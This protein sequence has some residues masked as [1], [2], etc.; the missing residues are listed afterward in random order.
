M[1][2]KAALPLAV[3]LAV[4]ALLCTL[5][6]AFAED[7]LSFLVINNTISSY[8]QSVNTSSSYG[9]S[10]NPD[11]PY[12]SNDKMMVPLHKLVGLTNGLNLRSQWSDDNKRLTVYDGNGTQLTF[13]NGYGTAFSGG[14]QYTAPLHR[15]KIGSVFYV[16]VPAELICNVFGL[17]YNRVNEVEFTLENGAVVKATMVRIC[18]VPY[19]LTDERFISVFNKDI[20]NAH[21]TYIKDNAPASPLPGAPSDMPPTPVSPPSPSP[22][23]VLNAVSLYLT[24]DGAPNGETAPLLDFLEANNLNALFFLPPESLAEN[25]AITRRI[26][27]RHQV[28]L[29]LDIPEGEEA[30]GRIRE[31]NALLRETALIKT[32]FIRAQNAPADSS[33]YLF[34]E[35]TETFGESDTA[36]DIAGSV[37]P[38]LTKKPEPSTVI[39]SLPHTAAA[40]DALRTLREVFLTNETTPNRIS[41]GEFPAA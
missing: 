25:P 29:L 1:K 18:T 38:L 32:W 19:L 5:P 30:L 23:P 21:E 35:A 24:F 9:P 33:E 6:P 8:G 2:R 20:I 28:G 17:Y 13:E 22:E 15:L 40:L 3:F 11:I 36:D 41:A 16:F 10:V 26:A 31:G 7:D 27:A 34:L 37:A 4:S 12:V 14:N 39:L